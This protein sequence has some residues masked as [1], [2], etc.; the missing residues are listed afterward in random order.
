MPTVPRFRAHFAG[1]A[2]RRSV[3]LP[4]RGRWRVSYFEVWLDATSD[5]PGRKL[6][7][8]LKTTTMITLEETAAVWAREPGRKFDGTDTLIY[9]GAY[10]DVL[11]QSDGTLAV[12]PVC[13]GEPVLFAGRRIEVTL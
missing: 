13:F 7:T 8:L 9:Q 3:L 4:L 10:Y 12:F 11:R 1:R 6:T 2:A 5:Q